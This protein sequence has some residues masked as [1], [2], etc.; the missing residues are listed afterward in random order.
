MLLFILISRI[1][2]SSLISYSTST[3]GNN[4]LIYGAG[5]LG[6]YASTV[7]LKYSVFGYIDDDINKIGKKI[8]NK[9]I[10]KVDEIENIIKLNNIKIIIIAISNLNINQRRQIILSLQNYTIKTV[11][12]P[13]FD[14]FKSDVR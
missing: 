1:L 5:N 14:K 2:Y 6:V 13:N 7:L 8:N 3:T 10:Y 4:I 12:F 9:E 11:F